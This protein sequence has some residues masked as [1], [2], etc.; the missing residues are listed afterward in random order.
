MSPKMK[1][2]IIVD[3]LAVLI[4]KEITDSNRKYAASLLLDALLPDWKQ[5][6]KNEY[7]VLKR[8]DPEVRQWK[9]KVLNRDNYTCQKCGE[10][11]KLQVHHVV[12]WSKNPFSRTDIQNGITLCVDCHAEEHTDHRNL[13]LSHKK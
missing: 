11:E 12:P 13:I 5:V 2:E 6:I 4:S 10:V 7:P 8:S 9:K 3:A 1:Y